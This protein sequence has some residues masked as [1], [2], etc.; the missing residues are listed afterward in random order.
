MLSVPQAFVSSTNITSDLS[1]NVSL[2]EIN[3]TSDQPVNGTCCSGTENNAMDED[4]MD[5]FVKFIPIA[6]QHTKVN[7]VCLLYREIEAGKT[8]FM[9]NNCHVLFLAIS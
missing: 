2:A 8:M 3:T 7:S 6:A 5:H 1:M 4:V 9:N